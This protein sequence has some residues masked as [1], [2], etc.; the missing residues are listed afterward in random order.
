VSVLDVSGLRWREEGME[1][2]FGEDG[3]EERC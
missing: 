1:A 3:L 2:V